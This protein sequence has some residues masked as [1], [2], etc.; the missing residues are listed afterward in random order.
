MLQLIDMSGI[1]YKARIVMSHNCTHDHLVLACVQSP[2]PLRKIFF[3]RGAG[4]FVHRLISFKLILFTL[5][6]SIAIEYPKF[7]ILRE[8]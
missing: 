6:Q 1:N 4:R 3:L 7:V 8:K 5:I 2:P